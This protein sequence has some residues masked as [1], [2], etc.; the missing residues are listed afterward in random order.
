[1]K[2]TVDYEGLELTVEYEY[3]PFE[4]PERHYPGCPSDVSIYAVEVSGVDIL[5]ILQP[6]FLMSLE[7]DVLDEHQ[8]TRWF[9]SEV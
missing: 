2:T 7:D 4:P 9:N 5:E 8:R 3:Q 1:M 6:A